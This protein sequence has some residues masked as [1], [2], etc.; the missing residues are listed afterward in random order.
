M[1]IMNF[2]SKT[3]PLVIVLVVTF[4]TLSS[5]A[6]DESSASLPFAVKPCTPQESWDWSNHRSKIGNT[7]V[8]E[9]E[10]FLKGKTSQ[11]RSFSEALA[12]RKISTPADNQALAEYWISRTLLSAGLIHLAHQ[13]F[14]ALI[15]REIV[16]ATVPYQLA[17]LGC[18]NVIRLKQSALSLEDSAIRQISL[19]NQA[20]RQLYSDPSPYKSVV[21]E[22]NFHLARE[23]FGSGIAAAS[24]KLLKD[25]NSY[26]TLA[27]AFIEA[28]KNNF[29][30]TT[31]LMELFFSDSKR[32]EISPLLLDEAHLIFARS[33]Y[34]DGRY[35]EAVQ[36]YKTISTRSN[37]WVH[38]LSELSWSYLM[39]ERYQE[40]IGAG[41]G[42]QSGNL[43]ST[44]APEA[45]MVMSIALN[46]ICRFP[47]SM[48]MIG[49]FRKNY[50]PAYVWLTAHS[51]EANTPQLYKLAIS[52]MKKAQTP[53]VP[54]VNIGSE[55]IRSP[56]FLA[57][58]ERLNLLIR[59]RKLT[60]QLSEQGK[61][62]QLSS[63][64]NLILKAKDL[65]KRLNLAK[66]KL[67]PGEEISEKLIAEVNNLRNDRI[68]LQR[69]KGAGGIWRIIL[70]R[71][72]ASVPAT[73]AKLALTISKEISRLNQRMLTQ[74]EEIAENNELIEVEIYNAASEDMIWQNAHPDYKEI[75][76]TLKQNSHSEQAAK[77]WN[78]GTTDGGFDGRGEVWEDEVGSLSADLTDNCDNKDKYLAIK[79]KSK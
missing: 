43:R 55:W 60:S 40:S 16:P 1:F 72:Q 49:A 27:K 17:A 2:F 70:T 36:Q 21:L 51:A 73:Q 33:L 46:E 39:D 77:V 26:E 34:E 57:N 6:D 56:V 61:S 53:D 47:E 74:L 31:R 78:W 65:R 71:Y 19:L 68:H 10:N 75:A 58:Q 76:K 42:L 25:T 59:E 15:A 30:E 13:G 18:L 4:T 38:A 32:P 20:S 28:S 29:K 69:L 14:H 24:L 9:F 37:E 79:S 63:T 62:E 35:A 50:H 11:V 45:L 41:I 66:I 52:F 8:T 22:A 7:W 54:P 48:N 64:L 12:F 23:H 3:L 67:K 5:R 44:F